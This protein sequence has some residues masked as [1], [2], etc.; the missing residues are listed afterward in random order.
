MV[1]LS[2]IEIGTKDI[3]IAIL[4][5]AAGYYIRKPIE[6]RMKEQKMRDAELFGRTA[7]HYLAEEMKTK[8]ITGPETYQ[9]LDEL[10]AT[11]KE[12][13]EELKRYKVEK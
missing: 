6:D 11:L 12:V 7:A 2:E 8:G 4:S 13:R 3:I 1:K 5:A 10:T 9:A